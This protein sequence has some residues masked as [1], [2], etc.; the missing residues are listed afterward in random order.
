[1]LLWPVLVVVIYYG[2]FSSKISHP[3]ILG[4]T[5]VVVGY[6]SFWPVELL[7]ENLIGIDSPFSVLL[8]VVTPI[9]T[10]HALASVFTK[11]AKGENR[12]CQL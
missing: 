7:I 1:M 5:S 2:L 10:T 11:K 9:A 3:T 4:I 8:F 6:A 12:K